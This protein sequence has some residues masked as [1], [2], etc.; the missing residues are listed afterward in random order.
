MSFKV[1]INGINELDFSPTGSASVSSGV[2]TLTLQGFNG[3]NAQTGTSYTFV[4]SDGLKLVTF[5]NAGATAVTLP[6]AGASFP[7]GW[8][9]FVE[10]LGAGAVTITPTTST[11]DGTTSVTLNQN[12]GTIIFSDGTNYWQMRGLSSIGG[13]SGTVTSVQLAV[14]AEFTVS[15]GPITSFGTITIGKAN[16][17]ANLVFAGPTT[18]APAAPSF[19]SLVAADIPNI[20]ESQVTNLTTDLAATEKTANKDAANGYAGL[21]ANTKLKLAEMQLAVNAQTG[22]SYTVVDGDRAKLITLSNAA[23]VAVTL[24]QAGASSQFIAGWFA[25]FENKG[26]GIVTITPTTS[27]IDGAASISLSQNQGC[28]VVSDGTNYSSMRGT[29]ATGSV[30]GTAIF[31]AS[32]GAITN[33]RTSGIVSGVTRTSTGF[34]L[35]TFSSV[36]NIAV[37][38]TC[39]DDD[40]HAMMMYLAHTPDLRGP[41][42]SFTVVCFSPDGTGVRDPGQVS[43]TIFSA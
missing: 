31:K 33:L 3:L 35:I 28:M 40:V 32:T 10:N 12:Q 29:G 41:L 34:F 4:N 30:L 42:T 13:A 8:A 37:A 27:T 15:G 2:S 14:P 21:D 24:P 1:N 38:H 5:N 16:E 39:S 25:Y 43:V 36:T 19:R 20:A 22:T 6:Q 23:A 18:G 9:V 17:S 11:I 26:A 7:A